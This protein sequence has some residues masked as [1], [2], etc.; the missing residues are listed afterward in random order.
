MVY[1]ILDITMPIENFLSIEVENFLRVSNFF[2]IEV[3]SS[4]R[5]VLMKSLINA[6]DC[7]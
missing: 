6:D 3:L 7:I 2:L 5:Q 4:S 1:K